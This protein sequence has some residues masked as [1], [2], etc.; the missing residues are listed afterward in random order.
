MTGPDL[1]ARAEAF[2]LPFYAAPGRTYHNAAH[3][4]QVLEALA[5]RGVL[6]PALSLAAWSHDLIHDPR[7]DDNEARSAA[8]FGAWL[9]AQGAGADLIRE[10]RGLILATRHNLFPATRAR[11]LLADADLGI[12]GSDPQAFAAYDAAI[13]REYAFV[14]EAPYRAGRAR[15]LRSFLTR[16]RIYWAPE[17]AGLE[18]QARAN[19]VAALLRLE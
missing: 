9:A 6:T 2:A 14:P 16:E 19:L 7:A 5:S 4:R 13:R 15:V 17:F 3:V 12:L 8:T 10:V 18:A 11:A 1:I